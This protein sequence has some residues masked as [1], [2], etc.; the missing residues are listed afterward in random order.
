VSGGRF[1]GSSRSGGRLGGADASGGR[2]G[3]GGTSG[4]ST[5]TSRVAKHAKSSAHIGHGDVLVLVSCCG[6]LARA[7]RERCGSVIRVG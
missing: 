7:L 1:G 4:T 2:L 5:V 6:S 3:G